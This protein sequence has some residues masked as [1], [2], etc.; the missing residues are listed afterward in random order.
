MPVTSAAI[1]S[2]RRLRRAHEAG[3]EEQI[4]RRIA[5][6]R[7]L[8]QNDE[9][10]SGLARLAHAGEDQRAIPVEV[11]DDRIDSARARSS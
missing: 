3:A 4:L 1:A 8:R 6:H 9:I 11:A 2:M 7:E 5:R 10:G